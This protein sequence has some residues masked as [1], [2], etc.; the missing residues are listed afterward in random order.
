MIPGEHFP[1]ERHLKKAMVNAII[2]FRKTLIK[3]SHVDRISQGTWLSTQESG[4]GLILR[5]QNDGGI[6]FSDFRG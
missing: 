4:C 5:F 6:L 2:T 3:L 1:L